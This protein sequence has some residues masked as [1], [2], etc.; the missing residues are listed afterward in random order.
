MVAIESPAR[1]SN[2][3][4]SARSDG[5]VQIECDTVK[6][7]MKL[8]DNFLV[9]FGKEPDGPSRAHEV[10]YPTIDAADLTGA[11]LTRAD[12]RGADLSGANLTGADLTDA[13]F[14]DADLT[15][16]D[17]TDSCS[18]GEITWPV[19]YPPPALRDCS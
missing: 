19:D 6:G 4:S 12:L 11:D 7:G 17:F 5:L 1:T 13:D 15:R 9:D 18:N 16:V 14:T 2:P 8:N 3:L 10:R